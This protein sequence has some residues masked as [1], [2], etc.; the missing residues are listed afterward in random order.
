MGNEIS[1]CVSKPTQ[2][3]YMSVHTVNVE[4]QTP[5]INDRQKQL[6][7]DTWSIAKDD[8]AKVGVVTFLR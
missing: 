2:E 1:H 7:R 5:P 4:V 6:L 3:T 8:I